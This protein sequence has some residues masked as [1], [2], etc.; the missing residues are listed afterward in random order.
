MALGWVQSLARP[1]GNITGF[2]ANEPS[3]GAKWL[4]LLKEIAPGTRRVAVIEGDSPNNFASS[5]VSAADRFGVKVS[6]P[7]IK[8]ADD[9][10]PAIT[11][12]GAAP[13]GGLVVPINAFTAIH[14]KQIVE[15]SLR[16]KLPLVTGNP[17]YP[18]EG[19]L[20]YYGADV[21]DIYRRSASYVD[22]ILRGAR[23]ADL[24]VQQPTKYSLVINL[25]TAKVLGLTVPQLLLAQ[26]DEVIE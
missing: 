21:D 10:A 11:D 2:S 26:A 1:G 22:R 24:P 6:V 20:L 16:C 4:E 9:L 12:F 14:R 23:P 15:L 19:G 3:F 17:P 7:P 5:I 13:N 18:A 8:A 25:K